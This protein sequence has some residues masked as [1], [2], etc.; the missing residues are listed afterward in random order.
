MLD[1][2]ISGKHNFCF[3]EIW[4]NNIDYLLLDVLAT[5]GWII[6]RDN[7]KI[8]FICWFT[9]KRQLPT[10]NNTSTYKAII[11]HVT[12]IHLRNNLYN[13]QICDLLP[14]S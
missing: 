14:R 2:K 12:K 1:N 10:N 4:L 7:H 6:R 11:F 3:P 13:H 8:Q 5:A 9:H